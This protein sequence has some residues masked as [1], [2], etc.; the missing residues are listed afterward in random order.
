MFITGVKDSIV[1]QEV[2]A[3]EEARHRLN[4]GLFSR[5]FVYRMI[6]QKMEA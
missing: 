6:E 4:P 1:D 3:V 2:A 5:N